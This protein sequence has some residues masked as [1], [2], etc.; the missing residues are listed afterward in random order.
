MLWR[1]LPWE[2]ERK[3]YFRLSRPPTIAKS[4]LYEYWTA[5]CCCC[6]FCDVWFVNDMILVY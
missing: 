1:P 5:A 2:I 3:N 6:F 4:V